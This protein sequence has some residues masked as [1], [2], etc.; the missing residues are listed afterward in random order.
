[1]LMTLAFVQRNMFLDVDKKHANDI[2]I[3]STE[4]AKRFMVVGYRYTKC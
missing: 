2:S 1:M 3:C 4:K